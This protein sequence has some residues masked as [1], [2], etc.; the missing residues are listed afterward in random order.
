MTPLTNRASRPGRLRRAGLVSV[1]AMGLLVPLAGIAPSQAAAVPTGAPVVSTGGGS[2]KEEIN[3]CGYVGCL[4]DGEVIKVMTRNI[5]LGADLRPAF[6][7]DGVAGFV[8]ANGEIFNQVTATNMPTRSKGLAKEI[9]KVQPDVV[10]L[11]EAALWRTGPVDFD[12][13]LNQQPVATNVYQ[14]FLK[15]LMKRLN[16]NGKT[17]RVALVNDEFDFEGPADTDGNPN[18]GPLG[19]DINGRLTMRDAILIKRGAGIK[20]KGERGK[21]YSM[22]YEVNVAGLVNVKVLRGWQS[23]KVKIRNSPW[24]RFSNTHLESFD[25]RTQRP[26][27][28]AQQAQ[29]LVDKVKRGK[30]P[31]I[32]VGDFNSDRPGLV[33]GDGQAYNVMRDNGYRSVGTK[34]PW[35]CCISGSYDL[36]TG[37]KKD[38][39]HRV[40]QIFTSTPKKVKKISTKVTGR[41]KQNGY[42]NSDHAGVTSQLFVFRR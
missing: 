24:I 42:W 29:E 5:Y 18:T 12:A 25:D 30:Q 28:R 36:M 23:L 27:L 6:E 22:G 15:I 32:V 9:R 31:N 4:K 10:G 35:S 39:D 11:Q 13:A 38:F 16:K 8:A 17:Y 21:H 26:S 1:V 7:A 20:I 14:D 33:P 34:D 41:K 37:S 40:D 2:A 3:I 19:A